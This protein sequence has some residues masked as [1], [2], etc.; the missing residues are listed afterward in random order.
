MSVTHHLKLKNAGY[1]SNNNVP[2]IYE[3][4]SVDMGFKKGDQLTLSTFTQ[5]Y[6]NTKPI[7]FSIV[8]ISK[9]KQKKGQVLL[10]IKKIEGHS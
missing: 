8:D 10:K 1:Q 2:N 3:I 4:V 6:L 7:Y 9:R 5:E